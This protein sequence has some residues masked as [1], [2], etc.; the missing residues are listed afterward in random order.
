M[1]SFESINSREINTLKSE[2][3][4]KGIP[5]VIGCI[6]DREK[7]RPEDYE[8]IS[9][10]Q[11]NAVSVDYFMNPNK[12][13]EKGFCN[14]GYKT[15]VISGI[16]EANKYT[17]QL[18]DCTSVIGV[19]VDKTTKRN[20]SF[21]S[22]QDPRMFLKDRTVQE[23]FKNDL[24]KIIN[25][26]K[27]RCIPG[28]IDIVIEGGNKNVKYAEP[29]KSVDFDKLNIQ[30]IYKFMN[31]QESGPFE[32]YQKSIKFLNRI[33]FN[34]IGFSP[35]VLVGPNSNV[36]TEEEYFFHNNNLDLYFDTENRRAYQVR[37]KNES[38]NNESFLGD[39]IDEKFKK[40]K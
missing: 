25:E 13:A 24:N 18:L 16:N 9:S 8:K 31:E 23:N 3:L 7:L 1:S 33:I 32:R 40:Y 30:E 14:S 34:N 12:A 20:I 21:L 19:G 11:K 2:H 22:H 38:V 28:T 6:L 37:V 15:Y 26:L 27:D 29:I 10:I 35:T 5:P 4:T 17:E 36:K 39:E